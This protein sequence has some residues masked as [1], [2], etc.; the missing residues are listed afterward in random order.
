MY[1]IA[2]RILHI[3]H[4]DL[5]QFYRPYAISTNIQLLLAQF[6]LPDTHVHRETGNKLL[7]V[8]KL[9][10]TR[11]TDNFILTVILVLLGLLVHSVR[12]FVRKWKS[13]HGTGKHVPASVQQPSASQG[14]IWE[15]EYDSDPGQDLHKPT[16]PLHHH[17]GPTGAK[18]N[19]I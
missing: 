4:K 16:L 2:V 9:S 3:K 6:F 8:A 10:S 12:S 15:L 11:K 1:D 7:Y 13:L 19:S 14:C 5:K 18:R 17:N